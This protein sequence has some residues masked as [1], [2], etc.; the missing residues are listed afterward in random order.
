M[1]GFTGLRSVFTTQDS[2][3]GTTVHGSQGPTDTNSS[4]PFAADL[5]AASGAGGGAAASVDPRPRLEL[6]LATSSDETAGPLQLPF[7]SLLVRLSSLAG[8]SEDRAVRVAAAELLHACL[9]YLVGSSV[10]RGGG[11]A[12]GASAEGGGATTL[13]AGLLSQ[14]LPKVRSAYALTRIRCVRC[15]VCS[16]TL[17]PFRQLSDRPRGPSCQLSAKQNIVCRACNR[18]PICLVISQFSTLDVPS[19]TNTRGPAPFLLRHVWN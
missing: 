7:D 3:R 2:A 6:P 16:Q 18:A 14:L 4:D 15:W 5:S 1:C 11:A 12:A 8:V 19:Y 9:L 17:C 13:Q 10:S